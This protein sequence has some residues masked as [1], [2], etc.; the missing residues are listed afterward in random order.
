MGNKLELEQEMI[1]LKLEKRELLLSGKN[2]EKIDILMKELEKKIE[3]G[4]EVYK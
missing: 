3:E 4:L 1:V 2:T